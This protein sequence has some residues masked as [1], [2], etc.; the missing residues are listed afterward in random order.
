MERRYAN[1]VVGFNARMTDIHAAIG[2]VQLGKLPRWQR[3]MTNVPMPDSCRSNCEAS[4]IPLS[5]TARRTF[6][7]NTQSSLTATAA[8][9]DRMA[10]AL[11]RNTA[12]APGVPPDSAP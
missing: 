9:R 4:P 3:E 5:R 8:E 10:R 2:R 1:E 6:S 12:S 11:A 7:T